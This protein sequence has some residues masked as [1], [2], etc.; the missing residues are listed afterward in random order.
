MWVLVSLRWIRWGPGSE[1]DEMCTAGLLL[2]SLLG[3]GGLAAASL[4]AEVEV[5]EAE[6]AI[7]QMTG[8]KWPTA[9][10]HMFSS[11]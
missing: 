5:I 1:G 9:A 3:A 4:E 2:V 8:K 7:V 10:V 6:C 11:R